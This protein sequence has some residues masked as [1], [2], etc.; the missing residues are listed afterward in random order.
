MHIVSDSLFTETHL[1][2]SIT[3][4][5]PRL[6]IV[7]FLKINLDGHSS[8]TLSLLSHG[9]EDFLINDDIILDL[10]P[11]HKTALIRTDN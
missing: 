5:I 8:H 3:N 7:E 9:M 10:P 1:R 11:R 2:H 6:P 4:K